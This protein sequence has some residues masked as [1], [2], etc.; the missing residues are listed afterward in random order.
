[1][2]LES[3][4]KRLDAKAEAGKVAIETG[5]YGDYVEAKKPGTRRRMQLYVKRIEKQWDA[6]NMFLAGIGGL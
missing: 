3:I 1:M 6:R 4:Q 2:L 5:S